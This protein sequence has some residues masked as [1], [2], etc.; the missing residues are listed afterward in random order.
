MTQG[1]YLIKNK[2][3]NRCYI[4][5]SIEIERRWEEHRRSSLDKNAVDYNTPLHRAFR[6]YGSDNFSLS[7]LEVVEEHSNLNSLENKYMR[8]YNSVSDG[9][10][11]IFT[12]R[13]GLSKNDTITL[14]ESKY[15]VTKDELINRLTQGTFEE[16]GSYYGVSSNAIRKWCKD[17]GIPSRA[18]D[19]MTPEKKINFSKKMKVIA[20]D[21]STS[22]KRVIML[23]K[24]TEEPI[25]TFNS[26]K[27]ASEFV[28]VPSSNLARTIRGDD[29][30]KTAYGYKWYY[31]S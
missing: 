12:S 21:S 19:Y 14:R 28:G 10:N 4:G 29:N 11:Q 20:S 26:L 2:V 17:Y 31:S 25:R 27:E 23:D 3:N 22:K 24:H 6:K 9:Y 30:R 15:G 8:V 18:K 1:I 7:I 5:Q 16:V 13:N